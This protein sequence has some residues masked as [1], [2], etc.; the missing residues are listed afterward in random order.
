MIG[1]SLEQHC[2]IEFEKLRATGFKAAY[3]EKIMRL[4]PAVKVIIS[5]GIMILTVMNLSQ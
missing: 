3:F 5:T 1:E 4:N 2:E